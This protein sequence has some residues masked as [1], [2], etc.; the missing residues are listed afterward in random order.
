MAETVTLD[1]LAAQI[2]RAL[3]DNARTRSDMASFREDMQ[4][5][6]AMVLRVDG[7]M[8]RLLDEVRARVRKLE[9]QATR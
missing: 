3:E 8:S 4:V 2:E 9:D 5:L 6:T 1:F 7:T